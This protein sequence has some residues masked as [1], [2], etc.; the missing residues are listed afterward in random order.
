MLFRYII[1]EKKDGYGYP[2]GESFLSEAVHNENMIFVYADFEV[3]N[4]RWNYTTSE[5]DEYTPPEPE[6]VQEP[7][8]TEQEQAILDTAVNI[9]YLVCLKEL[10][11]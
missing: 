7:P 10:E 8:L 9:D 6:P 1:I 11:I 3:E 2:V 4:K 5:W